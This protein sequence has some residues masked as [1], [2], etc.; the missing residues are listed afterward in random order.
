MYYGVG[1]L[2]GGWATV[3]RAS[4]VSCSPMPGGI[5]LIKFLQGWHVCIDHPFEVQQWWMRYHLVKMMM[6]YK[7]IWWISDQ[8]PYIVTIIRRE[9]FV[10]ATQI[11]PFFLFAVFLIDRSNEWLSRQRYQYCSVSTVFEVNN[12]ESGI[13]TFLR[14]WQKED[15]IKACWIRSIV[16]KKCICFKLVIWM[17]SFWW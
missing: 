11:I 16:G 3:E 17:Y 2:T 8:A 15:S 7:Y 9:N 10:D 12:I 5:V 6:V 4:S 13:H 1:Y 14:I